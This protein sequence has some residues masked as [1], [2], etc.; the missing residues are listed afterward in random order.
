MRVARQEGRSSVL[1]GMVAKDMAR[2]CF[3]YAGRAYIG[4]LLVPKLTPY[5]FG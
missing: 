3:R 2:A 1:D 5:G 4:L